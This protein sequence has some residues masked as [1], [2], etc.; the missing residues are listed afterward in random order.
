MKRIL[1]CILFLITLS[2]CLN[3][4]EP[5]VNVEGKFIKFCQRDEETIM[6]SAEEAETVYHMFKETEFKEQTPMGEGCLGG[7]ELKLDNGEMIQ[8]TITGSD[9][10][11]YNG[12]Q[13]KLENFD[14]Y[15]EGIKIYYDL[16][17]KEL[18]TIDKIKSLVIEKGKD[19][20]YD[21]F[22]D[23]LHFDTGGALA[24]KKFPIDSTHCLL[25]GNFSDDYIEL[26]KGPGQ[27]IDIRIDDIDEF[28]E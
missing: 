1:C 23:Y 4:D 9:G 19:L 3:N 11:I 13:Y 26:S 12:E 17:D 7:F 22:K 8:F 6:L 24:A 10:I 16:D 28:L 18:L 15:I 21:D 25:I 27:S 20:T 14:L 5:P 2:A